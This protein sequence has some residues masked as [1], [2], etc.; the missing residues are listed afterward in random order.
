M[1]SIVRIQ[2]CEHKSVLHVFDQNND[3]PVVSVLY[4]SS[5]LVYTHAYY[6]LF[7]V[8]VLFFM[9]SKWEASYKGADND[10]VFRKFF[11]YCKKTNVLYLNIS[12]TLHCRVE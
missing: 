8:K 9:V 10:W 1:Y 3:S 6:S 4:V 5:V 2:T 11:I 12:C 7:I